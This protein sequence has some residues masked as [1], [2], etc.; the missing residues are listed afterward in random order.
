MAND[1]LPS[2]SAALGRPP[3]R[4]ENLDDGL[5]QLPPYVRSL[6]QVR[7]PVMVTLAHARRPVPQILD[8]SPGTILQFAKSCDEPLTLEVNGCAIAQG[9]AVKVGDKFG[10]R[11]FQM[12][13]PEEKFFQL[14]AAASQSAE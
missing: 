3:I 5:T 8:I 12:T 13:L 9:E 1:A 11:I 2:D 10:L 4:F 6:L 14:R 7:V